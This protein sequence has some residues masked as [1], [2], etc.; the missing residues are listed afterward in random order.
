MA[1]DGTNVADGVPKNVLICKDAK[2][3]KLT[4]K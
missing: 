2:Q 3:K 1:D 4:A